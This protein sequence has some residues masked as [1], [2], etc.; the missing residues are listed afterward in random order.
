MCYIS[1]E[2]DDER[3]ITGDTIMKISNFNIDIQ[4]IVGWVVFNYSA[5]D[6]DNQLSSVTKIFKVSDENFDTYADKYNALVSEISKGGDFDGA[7]F[8]K[9]V[10]DFALCIATSNL[11]VDSV[12]PAGF[13][14]LLGDFDDGD[15]EFDPDDIGAIVEEIKANYKA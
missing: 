2:A 7:D 6:D 14:F 13:E 9:A 11:V 1:N 10:N 3:P 15:I 4:P 12:I 5:K 8:A